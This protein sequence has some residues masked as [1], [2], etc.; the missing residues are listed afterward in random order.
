MRPTFLQFCVQ[1]LTSNKNKA[2]FSLNPSFLPSQA[3][4]IHLDAAIL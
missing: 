3:Y 2:L 4:V 1:N